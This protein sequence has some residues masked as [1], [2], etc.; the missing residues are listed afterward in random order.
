MNDKTP[1]QK[2]LEDLADLPHLSFSRRSAATPEEGTDRGVLWGV[3]SLREVVQ[4][5]DRRFGRARKRARQER[6]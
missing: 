4:E 5:A 6:H 1:K 2:L 3:K